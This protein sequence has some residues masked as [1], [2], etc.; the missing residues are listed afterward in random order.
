VMRKTILIVCFVFVNMFA[1]FALP[2]LIVERGLG[3]IEDKSF[4]ESS[5]RENFGEV[6]ESNLNEKRE[7]SKKEVDKLNSEVEANIQDTD[8]YRGGKGGGSGGGSSSG[9]NRGG[10]GGIRVGGGSR[11]SSSSNLVALSLFKLLMVILAVAK[12]K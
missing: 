9:G 4:D 1:C 10:S 11:R 12:L 5:R 7:G 2:T 3:G 6:S 8:E